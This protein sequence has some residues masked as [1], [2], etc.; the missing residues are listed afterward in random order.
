[1]LATAAVAQV[2]SGLARSQASMA[3][4]YLAAEMAA[5]RSRAVMGAAAI[6]IRFG[7]SGTGYEMA[8]YADGNRNGLR[9]RDIADGTDRLLRQGERLSDRFPGVTVALV[10]DAGL[11][12]DPVKLG[13]S[14]LLTF[15]PAG[16]ATPGSVYIRGRDGSQFVVRITGATGRTRVERLLVR[17]ATWGRL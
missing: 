2:L 10:P 8:L 1:M 16:T 12:G 5:A 13:G 7:D 3:A 6:G 17:R 15:T 9:T 4:R 11:A 14:R